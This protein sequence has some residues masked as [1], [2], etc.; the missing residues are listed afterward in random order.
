MN[1]L[2][3]NKIELEYEMHFVTLQALLR[4]LIREH[5]SKT[6][7]PIKRADIKTLL[8]I[9]SFPE[10]PMSFYSKKLNIEEGSFSYIAKKIQKLG[11]VD[12]VTDEK[13]KRKKY[14]ILTEDGEVETLRLRKNMNKHIE[15]KLSCLNHDERE[16]FSN[17][18]N[19]LRKIC[20]K[21]Q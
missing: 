2:E 8:L 18:M 11:L 15:N 12:I 19:E 17:S 1:N 16:I 14:F 4:I 21:I 6:T 13:D 9:S 7:Y 5:E 3:N 10:K 20:K